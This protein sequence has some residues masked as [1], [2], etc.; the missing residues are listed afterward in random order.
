MT[1][2]HLMCVTTS[3]LGKSVAPYPQHYR[4]SSMSAPSH[5]SETGDR[6]PSSL[7]TCVSSIFFSLLSCST[8]SAIFS[9][10][11]VAWNTRLWELRTL[12]WNHNYADVEPLLRR[13]AQHLYQP[14][15]F[16]SEQ[17]VYGGWWGGQTSSWDLP[18]Q[19]S[20]H[21]IYSQ[22]MRQAENQ[23]TKRAFH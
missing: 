1:H 10:F 19:Q 22:V 23:H 20:W 2:I 13:N 14:T 5:R 15:L 8:D 21:Q 11:S 18:F 3:I 4:K 17:L 7:L 16:G 12:D 9:D 6:T